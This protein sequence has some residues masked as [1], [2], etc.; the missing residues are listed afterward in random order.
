MIIGYHAG[1]NVQ[2][3]LAQAFY[4]QPGLLFTTKGA[5]S[6]GSLLTNTYTLSYVEFPLN[7]VYKG[8]LGNGYFMLGFGP[9]AAYGVMGKVKTEGGSVS[10]ESDIVFKDVVESGDPIMTTYF[11]PLDAGANIFVGFET[12][13]GIFLQLNTQLGMLNIRPEDNRPLGDN[14]S[15]F[16]N[17]GYGLSLGFRF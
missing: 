3:P 16:K 7:F 8:S 10:V 9:Y 2:I 5:K 12:A 17:T 4:L 15:V 1:V 14:N 13:A 6:P 11:K